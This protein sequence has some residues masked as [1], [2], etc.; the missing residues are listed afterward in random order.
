MQAY[1][2]EQLRIARIITPRYFAAHECHAFCPRRHLGEGKFEVH[3]DVEEE[4]WR[5]LY[6]LEI[7]HKRNHMMTQSMHDQMGLTQ[8]FPSYPF[9]AFPSRFGFTIQNERGNYCFFNFHSEY[10]AKHCL[11]TLLRNKTYRWVSTQKIVTDDGLSIK[12]ETNT[13]LETI[14]EYKYKKNEAEWVTPEPYLT[15][16]HKLAGHE[17]I[18]TR[19]EPAPSKPRPAPTPSEPRPDGLIPLADIANELGIEPREA[20]QILRKTV[21]KPAYGWAW[22]K[23]MVD[24]IKR[25]L[26][27]K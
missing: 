27:G 3:Y 17:P 22:P 10:A 19:D 11:D 7:I 24:K 18:S 16:Y 23:E 1:I 20:R 4:K 5:G 8:P 6:S 9:K 12:G 25:T 13:D 15:Y 2:K 21:E 14:I 26:K